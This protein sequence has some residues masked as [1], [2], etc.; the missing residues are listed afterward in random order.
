M[1]RWKGSSG[2]LSSCS[3]TLHPAKRL[4]LA[5]YDSGRCQLAPVRRADVLFLSLLDPSP[6]EP[7]QEQHHRTVMS[8]CASQLLQSHHVSH[9]L[10]L[11]RRNEAK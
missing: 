8:Y 4:V 11:H 10:L 1:C 9:F 2:S 6:S 3:R 7:Q 5:L